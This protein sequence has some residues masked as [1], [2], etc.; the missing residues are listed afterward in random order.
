MKENRKVEETPESFNLDG[1]S[2]KRIKS[3]DPARITKEKSTLYS[4]LVL[5]TDIWTPP[6][7]GAGLIPLHLPRQERMSDQELT[8]LKSL[9]RG[10]CASRNSTMALSIYEIKISSDYRLFSKIL[11]FSKKN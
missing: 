6:G 10:V 8:Q 4:F 1:D 9:Q 11:L 3:I 5:G 7:S 2:S